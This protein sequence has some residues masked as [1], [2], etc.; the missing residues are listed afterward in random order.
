MR[1]CCVDCLE[2]LW[3]ICQTV[4]TLHLSSCATNEC[5]SSFPFPFT[6]PLFLSLFLSFFLCFYPCSSFFH[7]FSHSLFVWFPPLF[8]T[9]SLSLF[10]SFSLFFSCC[11]ITPSLFLPFSLLSFQAQLELKSWP[12]LSQETVWLVMSISR[13]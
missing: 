6:I 10:L 3:L 1:L 5:P 12:S 7:L 4:R 9:V 13:K 8:F 11:K 2:G